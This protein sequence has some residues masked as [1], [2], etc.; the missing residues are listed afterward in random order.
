[1]TWEDWELTKLVKVGVMWHLAL[2]GLVID[3][4]M[5]WTWYLPYLNLVEEVREVDWE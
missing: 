4:S 1:M 3:K 2:Y 5:T